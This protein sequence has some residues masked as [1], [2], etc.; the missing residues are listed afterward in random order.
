MPRYTGGDVT[1]SLEEL[2]KLLRKGRCG[3]LQL[4]RRFF[5]LVLILTY[6]DV[7]SDIRADQIKR[8]GDLCGVDLKDTIFKGLQ[9]DILAFGSDGSFHFSS[10]EV[11]LQVEKFMKIWVEELAERLRINSQ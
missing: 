4:L 11:A 10:Q 1:F 9:G 8:V 3:E 6:Q 2:M 5:G 7:D